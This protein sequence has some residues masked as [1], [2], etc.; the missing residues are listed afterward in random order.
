MVPFEQRLNKAL[1]ESPHTIGM[2]QND[3]REKE[4]MIRGNSKTAALKR[5]FVRLQQYGLKELQGITFN[6]PDELVQISEDLGGIPGIVNL[7][8]SDRGITQHALTSWITLVMHPYDAWR[9]LPD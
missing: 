3:V 7:I 9:H 1:S 8:R 4:A 5:L 2:D 6:S